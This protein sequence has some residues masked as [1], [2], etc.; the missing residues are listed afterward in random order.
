VN[1]DIGSVEV[2]MLDEHDELVNPL[3]ALRR[4]LAIRRR[5]GAHTSKEF[6]S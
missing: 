5:R 4:R 3:L 1:A 2:E 6:L